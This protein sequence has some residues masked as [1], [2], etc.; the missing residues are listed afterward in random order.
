V[1]NTK[2]IKALALDLDGVVYNGNCVIPGAVETIRQIRAYG[3]RVFF[4][5]NNS[6]KKREYIAEKLRKMGIDSVVEN[7]FTSAYATAYLL[8]Q[9]CCDGNKRVFVVGSDDLREEIVKFDINVVDDIP[10]DI[11]VVGYDNKFDYEKLSKS[12]NALRQGAIFVACNRDRTFP[13]ENNQVLPACGPIVASIEYAWGEKPNFEVGKPNI[14]LLEM[15]AAK[16][17]LKAN[18]IL[19]VGDMI[20]SDIVMSKK[21]GS[22][23]VLISDNK[24]YIDYNIDKYGD[25]N[26]D[27]VVSNIKDLV[28]LFVGEDIR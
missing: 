6:G 18:E 1:L 25:N 14:M 27:M 24:E 26:P 9:L 15:I 16:H 11:L 7:I 19:V 22:Q 2:Y 20:D 8:N 12:L 23:S 28:P 10:C 17:D 13:I 5:T 3:I 4:V 21:F